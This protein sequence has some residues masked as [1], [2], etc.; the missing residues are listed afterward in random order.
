MD[1]FIYFKLSNVDIV[2]SQAVEDSEEE[3][4]STTEENFA[5]TQENVET[6]HYIEV[7]DEEALEEAGNMAEHYGMDKEEF[8]KQ[9]GGLEV[10]KYDLRMHKALDILSK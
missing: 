8:L 5:T 3:N 2:F 9:F 10:V 1:D 4:I 6:T 7:T